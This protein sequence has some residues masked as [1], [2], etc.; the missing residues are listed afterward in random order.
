MK[1]LNLFVDRVIKEF[2]AVKPLWMPPH[3]TI[4]G[5]AKKLKFLDTKIDGRDESSFNKTWAKLFEQG[6]L[7]GETLKVTFT[8]NEGKKQKLSFE[9]DDLK[10]IHLK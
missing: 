7:E 8:D 9:S 10:E 4:Y 6:E 5:V 3:K 2:K 1:P